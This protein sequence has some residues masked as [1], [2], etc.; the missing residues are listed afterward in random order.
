MGRAQKNKEF[1]AR[2]MYPL[3]QHTLMFWSE[4]QAVVA[5]SSVEADLGAAVKA[6]QEVLGM[7]SLWM[8][9]GETTRGHVMG[10]A[11]AAIGSIR[12]KGL[13]KVRHLNTSWLW[14]QQKK[15]HAN[16]S[17]TKGGEQRQRR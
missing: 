2:R 5:L 8:G 6:S 17:T 7:K 12:R 11:S 10:D 14:V 15:H 3:E 1:D 16:C 13:E 9:E 4:T